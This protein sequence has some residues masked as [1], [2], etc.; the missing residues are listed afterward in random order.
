M[1]EQCSGELTRYSCAGSEEEQ[2]TNK[3]EAWTVARARSRIERGLPADS[4]RHKAPVTV[5][6]RGRTAIEPVLSELVRSSSGRRLRWVKSQ[7]DVGEGGRKATK[8]Q[9]SGRL[10]FQEA[11]KFE[12]LRH[13]E[14]VP[15][16]PGAEWQSC[17]VYKDEQQ[18]TEDACEDKGNQL[19][20]KPTELGYGKGSVQG[21]VA[22]KAR[23]RFI[24][25]RILAVWPNSPKTGSIAMYTDENFRR[26]IARER[27]AERRRSMGGLGLVGGWIWM[28]RARNAADTRRLC[29]CKRFSSGETR[30]RL[31]RFACGGVADSTIRATLS[32]MSAKAAR[33]APTPEVCASA[34]LRSD[35][36]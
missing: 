34:T 14:D 4:L 7:R 5:Y 1:D 9:Y 15:G 17:W 21:S 30:K 13:E 35:P 16:V 29:K 10:F 33:H 2:N 32:T 36:L 19:W 31:R 28:R 8:C 24:L 12:V 20:T 18:E 25:A 3:K 27:N 22:R 23:A 6:R 11:T 26:S